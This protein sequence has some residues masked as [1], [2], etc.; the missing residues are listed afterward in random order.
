MNYSLSVDVVKKQVKHF[1][2][3]T[4]QNN[5]VLVALPF[6]R[7]DVRIGGRVTNCKKIAEKARLG[8]EYVVMQPI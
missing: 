2:M 1:C 8:R 7:V 3:L 5:G 6:S 4:F